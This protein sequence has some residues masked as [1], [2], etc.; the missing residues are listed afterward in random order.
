M[1]SEIAFL[2]RDAELS[3]LNNLWASPR[4]A[5]LILYGRRRVG[6]TTLLTQW[7]AGSGRPGLYWVA[8]PNTSQEQLRSFSQALYRY[9]HAGEAA[10]PSFTFE[11]WDYAWKEVAAL[12]RTERLAVFIDEF[13][14]LL[15]SDPSVAGG[16]QNAWDHQLKETNL[17][18]ALSGSHLG[19]MTRQVLSYQAPLYGRA[20]AQIHLRPLPFGATRGYFP[21]FSPAQRVTLYSIFGGIPAY[22][23]QVDQKLTVSENIK[24]RLLTP[25]NFM[26][27]E[28]RLLLH[29]FVREPNNYIAILQ[30][31]SQNARAQN[32]IARRTGLPQGHVSKYLSVL[33]EA[34]FV[35]RRTPVTAEA[36]SRLGRYHVTDPYLRFYYRFLAPRQEQLA[37]GAQA[38]ALDEIKRHLLDFIG[39][40]TWEEICREWLLRA[41]DRGVLPFS[42]DQ[43]GASWTKDAQAD[44]VGI[45]RMEKTLLLGECKWAPQA[46]GRAVL[47]DL[48]AK[49]PA[50]VP[51]EGVWRVYFLG[52]ARGGWTEAAH[53]QAKEVFKDPPKRENWEAA[54]M[55]LLDLEQVDRDLAGWSG[56]ALSPGNKAGA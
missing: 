9:S 22:W 24:K 42:P 23:E 29:D 33:H 1:K 48:M 7:L 39:T 40:H 21:N 43:V 3:L 34:G 17:F 4:A 45:N 54:G 18:L 28:P 25:N 16:L 10:P 36:A 44:V 12:A 50:F 37:L 53:A 15:E 46:A 26:Q 41:G 2:G 30:A 38:R 52:F 49:S 31:I 8:A 27:D 6:K 56:S 20:A 19:M 35:E 51:K 47:V 55:T 32:E 11:T 14:Y 5:L 13:T